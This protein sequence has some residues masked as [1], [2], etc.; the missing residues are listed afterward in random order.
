MGMKIAEQPLMM[1]PKMSS[2]PADFEDF[3]L[4]MTASVI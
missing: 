4:L 2:S 1:K 3:S